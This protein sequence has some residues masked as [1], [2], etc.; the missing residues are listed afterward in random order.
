L[1]KDVGLLLVGK[2][3][4]ETAG[5][6][7]LGLPDPFRIGNRQDGRWRRSTGLG[8]GRRV[9]LRGRARPQAGIRF[10]SP[11]GIVAGRLFKDSPELGF[12]RPAEPA[13][14][15]L[16]VVGG[17]LGHAADGELGHRGV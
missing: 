4:V 3:H 14:T 5:E 7:L 13:C 1:A 10:F 8:S 16:E 2:V 12:Q 15:G 11:S 6:Q 17:F 9:A